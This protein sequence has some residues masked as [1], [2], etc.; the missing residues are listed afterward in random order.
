MNEKSQKTLVDSI[1]ETMAERDQWK[2]K[3]ERQNEHAK[4]FKELSDRYREALMFASQHL[5]SMSNYSL[6]SGAID[7]MERALTTTAEVGE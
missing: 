4:G 3:Y 1:A 6:V 7:A 2:S 5:K